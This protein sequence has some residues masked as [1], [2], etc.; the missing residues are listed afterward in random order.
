MAHCNLA[1]HLGPDNKREFVGG[2]RYR[3]DKQSDGNRA[4]WPKGRPPGFSSGDWFHHSWFALSRTKWARRNFAGGVMGAVHMSGRCLMRPL[5]SRTSTR[6]ATRSPSLSPGGSFTTIA[7]T[8]RPTRTPLAVFGQYRSSGCLL[9][10]QF[11]D[12]MEFDYLLKVS[13][14]V[15]K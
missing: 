3:W 14:E 12:L 11:L 7:V 15:N 8:E 6:T 1:S 9:L 5:C 4:S 10:T 2:P 13:S